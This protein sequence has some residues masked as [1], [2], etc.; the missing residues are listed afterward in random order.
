M[1][2][3]LGESGGSKTRR[4]IVKFLKTEGPTDAAR[5]ARRLSLTPRAVRQ[6]LYDLQKQNFVVAEARAVPMGR[7][8]KYWRLTRQA[9]RFFPDAYAE[10]S[11]SLLDALGDAF[12][13]LGLNRVL[14]A[15]YRSQRA[16]YAQRRAA[17]L[18]PYAPQRAYGLSAASLE[19]FNTIAPRPSRAE[20]ASAPSRALVSRN[21]PNTLV[22]SARSKSSQAV[23]ASKA[24]GV[25]PRSEALL[26]RTSKPP[27]SPVI[28]TAMG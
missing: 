20:A 13:E 23:S 8:A 15:R 1:A 21:G 5:I 4:A 19:M 24:S 9:D 7:P 6:H 27:S 28:C 26:T 18:A 12:G 14:D 16:N 2:G 17:L 3:A 11:V 10:L 22:A 25:G